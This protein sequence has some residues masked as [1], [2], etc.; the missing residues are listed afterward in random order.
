MLAG[1]AASVKFTGVVLTL[2]L[3]ATCWFQRRQ[4]PWWS[5]LLT[6]LFPLT[7]FAIFAAL[8]I[9]GSWHEVCVRQALAYGSL[10]EGT[11]RWLATLLGLVA[12]VAGGLVVRL[13]PARARPEAWF[14]PLCLTSAVLIAA[15]AGVMFASFGSEAQP[16]LRW[17]L[18]IANGL[19]D[20]ALWT[21][22][23]S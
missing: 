13:S 21:S 8:V 9:G 3:L 2:P 12:L 17:M 18:A 23:S 11:G 4:L 15:S 20:V 6:A 14:S 19:N 16:W 22:V 1:C 10:S 5:F 7:Y